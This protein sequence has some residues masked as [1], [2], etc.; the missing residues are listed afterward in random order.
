MWFGRRVNGWCIVVY[1]I[2]VLQGARYKVRFHHSFPPEL[3]LT[4]NCQDI[5]CRWIQQSF[6]I[7]TIPKS[8]SLKSCLLPPNICDSWCHNVECYQYE[9][10]DYRAIDTFSLCISLF[11]VYSQPAS[12]AQLQTKYPRERKDRPA[13]EEGTLS[14]NNIASSSLSSVVTNCNWK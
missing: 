1:T 5:I 4:L 11:S 3:F 12:A 9:H 8:T 6:T 10:L 2:R 14:L 7:L 13:C